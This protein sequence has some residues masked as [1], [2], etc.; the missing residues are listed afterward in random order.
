VPHQLGPRHSYSN[1]SM[2][3][4][5]RQGVLAGS[6]T[7]KRGYPRRTPIVFFPDQR[8]EHSISPDLH[9]LPHTLSNLQ[10]KYTH[11]TG[12]P[13]AALGTR[14][15]PLLSPTSYIEY[16]DRATYVAEAMSLPLSSRM[17]TTTMYASYVLFR[18]ASFVAAENT[19]HMAGVCFGQELV[20]YV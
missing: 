4:A 12:S 15:Y 19:I 2:Q 16:Q 10:P 8:P 1:C 18:E 5:H 7:A 20:R 17:V 3:A 13:S 14:H 9:L 6:E 11:P